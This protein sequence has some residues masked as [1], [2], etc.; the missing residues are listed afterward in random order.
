MSSA[1][2]DDDTPLPSEIGSFVG[3]ADLDEDLRTLAQSNAE[4]ERWRRLSLRGKAAAGDAGA[5]E[6]PA[7]TT[8]PG[9]LLAPSHEVP[10]SASPK[11]SGVRPRVDSR[12]APEASAGPGSSPD[13]LDRAA[14][15]GADLVRRPSMERTVERDVSY[16]G[17]A[18]VLTTRKLPS[19]PPISVGPSIARR[20]FALP[21][22]ALTRRA[23]EGAGAGPLSQAPTSPASSVPGA[24][25]APPAG[26][27]D[28][29]PEGLGSEP[30][31]SWWSAL[32]SRV[33]ASL[34]L[35]RS[36]LVALLLF[37]VL[38]IV[39]V[40]FGVAYLLLL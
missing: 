36:L 9:D 12:P 17:A 6:D 25:G 30:A 28:A 10:A 4:V 13:P 23:D 20:S 16:L 7:S 15:E 18:G 33:D 14:E 27:L 31:P 22:G 29:G 5:G 26:P 11:S 38:A 1:P 19:Y 21:K 35:D 3:L 37:V 8:T 24:P 39:F 40:V 2:H 34:E 32:R